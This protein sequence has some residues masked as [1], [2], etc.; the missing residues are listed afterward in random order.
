MID[1][2]KHIILNHDVAFP[3]EIEGAMYEKIVI[4]EE[5]DA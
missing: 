4:E 1:L 3:R 5:E 2:V